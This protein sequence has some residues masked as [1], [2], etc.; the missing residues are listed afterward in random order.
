MLYI[1]RRK[2][3]ASKGNPVTK[4]KS[5]DN[6]VWMYKKADKRGSICAFGEASVV[7]P[8][9]DTQFSFLFLASNR[10]AGSETM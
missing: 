3:S 2:K 8:P 4:W 10:P 1:D 7:A 6:A 9:R 5:V